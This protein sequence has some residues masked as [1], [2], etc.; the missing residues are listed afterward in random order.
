MENNPNPT[1]TPAPEPTAPAPEPTPNPT[2]APAPE[3]VPTPEPVTPEPASAPAPEPAPAPAPEPTPDPVVVPAP[4]PAP[5]P[6]P[7]PAPEAP[8]AEPTVAPE[9]VAPS[10]P[11]ATSPINPFNPAAPVENPAMNP[12]DPNAK[13]KKKMSGGV[14]AAIIVGAIVLLGGLGFLLFTMLGK[15]PNDVVNNAFQNVFN[16]KVLVYKATMEGTSNEQTMTYS[17]E[18]IALENGEAYFRV[19]GLGQLFG[20]LISAFSGNSGLDSSAIDSAFKEIEAIWWKIEPGEE[21]STTAGLNVDTSSIA[22][23]KRQKIAAAL[24][25]N[26][27]FIAE[28]VAQKSYATSGDVYKITVDKDKLAAYKNAIGDDDNELS[29]SGINFDNESEAPI[30]AT[31]NSPLFGN[32]VLTGIYTEMTSENSTSKISIDFE[33]T[34]KTAPAESKNISEMTTILQE[35]LG[36]LVPNNNDDDDN[37]YSEGDAE[38]RDVSR[39]NDYATLSA[40]ITGYITNNNGRLPEVGILDATR[41]I[42]STGA[43]PSG[44]P[45]HLEVVDYAGDYEMGWGVNLGDDTNVYVVLHAACDADSKLIDSEGTRDFAIAGS[46]ESIDYYCEDNS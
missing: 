46:L 37:D 44:Y 43:D 28:K 21:E 6:E 2:P 35:S 33:H 26:P 15:N 8:I 7:A 34:Q 29:L 45:Y 27:F 3:P 10:E 20:A 5:V 40:N 1:P 25:A 22:F 23:D 38:Q 31:V 14:L 17:T 24:K 42:N 4:E 41:Y 19:E 36:G 9:I 30:Y 16:E 32:P 13:P 11:G 39:R 18:M 12:V